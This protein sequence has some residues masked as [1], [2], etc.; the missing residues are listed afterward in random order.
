MDF[1]QIKLRPC[2]SAEK[3][4]VQSIRQYMHTGHYKDT[5]CYARAY[6]GLP[7]RHQMGLL[8]HEIGHILV[9]RTKASHY[10]PNADRAAN[11]FFGITIRYAQMTPWGED[12][13][14]L[15][16]R[17]ITKVEDKAIFDD[18]RDALLLVP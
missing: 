17:D 6:W 11:K 2:P 16:P 8:A 5:I 13:Q 1:L 4:Y 3:D 12:L 10:E 9:L 14:F 15:L 7:L 18:L